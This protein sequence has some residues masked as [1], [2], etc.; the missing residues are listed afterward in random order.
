MIF[1]FSTIFNGYRAF[2]YS[3]VDR[4][5]INNLDSRINIFKNIVG[6]GSYKMSIPIQI[7]SDKVAWAKMNSVLPNTDGILHTSNELEYISIQ[8]ADCVPIFLVD[9]IKGYF[10]LVHSGWRG[11][12]KSIVINSVRMLEERGSRLKD[13]QFFLGPHIHQNDYEVGNDVT[14]KFPVECV[15]TR[16]EKLYLSISKKI[17]NDLISYGVHYKKIQVSDISSYSDLRCQSYRRDGSNAGRMY[18]FLGID[19]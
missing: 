1:D 11:T 18:A 10:G 6:P 13:I 12:V 9:E 14:S 4:G 7:H 5:S 16:D 2:I 3:D 8:V 15:E 19:G 17:I